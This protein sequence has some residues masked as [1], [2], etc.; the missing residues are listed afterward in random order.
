MPEIQNLDGEWVALIKEARDLG[1]S[2]DEVR[3]FLQS[4]MD[5]K[6]PAD[7]TKAISIK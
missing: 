2:I 6:L 7:K 1:I 3:I 5:G 4:V